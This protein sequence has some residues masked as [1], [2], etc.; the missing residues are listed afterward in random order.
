MSVGG[1]PIPSASGNIHDFL[2]SKYTA[3]RAHG[4]AEWAARDSQQFQ[5]R[6][7]NT[8]HQ[9]ETA[10]LRAAGL[11]PILSVSHGG[12]STPTAMTQPG[13][14]PDFGAQGPRFAGSARDVVEMINSIRQTTGMVNERDAAAAAHRASAFK[15][16]AEVENLPSSKYL[17]ESQAELNKMLAKLRGAEAH[18]LKGDDLFQSLDAVVGE[19]AKMG[20]GFLLGRFLGPGSK[21]LKTKGFS[22]PRRR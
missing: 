20:T 17:A 19:L 3:D 10:D 11:N 2:M 14:V 8:A 13:R 4:E 9:R 16:L 6:M 1:F 12:A 21:F 22:L 5:E 18:S 15:T 7:S